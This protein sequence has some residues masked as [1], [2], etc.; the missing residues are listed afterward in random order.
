MSDVRTW[1]VGIKVVD[2]SVQDQVKNV[3]VEATNAPQAIYMALLRL[4]NQGHKNL[5]VV[6]SPRIVEE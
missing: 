4:R 1:I 5:W 6:H 3:K 2:D